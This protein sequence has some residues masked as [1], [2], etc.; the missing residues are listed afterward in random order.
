V[1][2]SKSKKIYLEG[3][4]SYLEFSQTIR[5]Q[6]RNFSGSTPGWQVPKTIFNRGGQGCR[7]IPARYGVALRMTPRPRPQGSNTRKGCSRKQYDLNFGQE[8]NRYIDGG[9][10]FISVLFYQRLIRIK[11]SGL[12]PRNFFIDII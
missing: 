11:I 12:F 8:I 5:L 3:N 2:C 1:L 4:L 7:I 10:L 6:K 9:V